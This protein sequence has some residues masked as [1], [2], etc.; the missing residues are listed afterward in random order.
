MRAHPR[1]SYACGALPWRNAEELHALILTSIPAVPR[2]AVSSS[3]M[4]PVLFA[5]PTQEDLAR[6]LLRPLARASVSYVYWRTERDP[7]DVQTYIAEL[8]LEDAAHQLVA[9]TAMRS[10][11]LLLYAISDALGVDGGCFSLDVATGRYRRTSALP[12]HVRARAQSVPLETDE[13]IGEL[14]DDI[15]S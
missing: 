7:R 13:E 14:V 5:Q 1:A 11:F 8:A 4:T 6:R 9:R 10:G 15:A 12:E 3:C 2:R